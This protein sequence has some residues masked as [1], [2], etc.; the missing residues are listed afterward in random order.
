MEG[1]PRTGR[2]P[3]PGSDFTVRPC[4]VVRLPRRRLT[5][6]AVALVV[7]TGRVRPF[8]WAWT[9]GTRTG[10]A[11]VSGQRPSCNVP[12][13]RRPDREP[14]TARAPPGSW[15]LRAPCAGQI[16]HSLPGRG[17]WMS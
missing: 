14:A 9:S 13:P 11:G 10:A 3:S 8:G 2:G 7:D 15:G 16:S 1:A 4:A 6:P 17:L 5:L 12:V